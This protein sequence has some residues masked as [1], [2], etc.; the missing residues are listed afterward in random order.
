[1]RKAL[2][3]RLFG[4]G[5]MPAA[6]SAAARGPGVLLASEG[7]PVR[8]RVRSLQMPG[9]R[10][11]GVR[12][13]SGAIVIAPGRLLASVGRYVI[14]DADF[15][16]SGGRQQLALSGD[17]VRITFDV[18][19]VLPG[20]SGTVQVHYRLALDA[21]LLSQLPALAFPVSLTHA[22]EALLNPWLGSYAGGVQAKRPAAGE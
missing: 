6:L 7:L 3:Y 20:G 4:L 8:N 18:A 22:A 1:M 15:G 14:A 11:S 13:A 2:R 21:S 5:K 19:T 10:T 12:T 16:A 17:G 9:A